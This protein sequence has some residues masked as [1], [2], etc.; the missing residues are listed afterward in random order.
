[1]TFETLLL[2]DAGPVAVLTLNRPTKL[3]AINKTMLEELDR[4]ILQVEENPNVYAVVLQGE[5]R[6]FCA[7]FDLKSGVE[8]Q[9]EG[10]ADWRPAI[11][12]DLDVIMRFWRISKPTIAAVHGYVLAGGFELSLACDLTIAAEG[13]RFGSP[14]VRFGSSIAALLLPWYVNPKRAKQMILTGND[15]ID[16][17]EACNL[18]IINEVVPQGQERARAYELAREMALMDPDSLRLNKQ[19]INRT[20]EMMGLNQALDMGV[21]VSVQIESIE[22]PARRGFNKVLQESGMK[23]ALEWR[24]AQ[25][26]KD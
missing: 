20:Y 12:R 25:F 18:G 9:R 22:T 15:K 8:T 10:V 24:E 7:G 16:A 14:E 26:S 17:L 4:A 5:G 13:S 19:A 11:Q 6:A 21:D 3:N 2:D 23:E 1:M